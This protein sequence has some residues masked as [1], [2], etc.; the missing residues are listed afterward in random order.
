MLAW[1][2]G[3]YGN[4]FYIDEGERG[5]RDPAFRKFK[6]AAQ[7]QRFLKVHAAVYNLFNLGRHLVRRNSMGQGGTNTL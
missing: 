3:A 2:D 1:K 5:T 4:T 7:T 6:S